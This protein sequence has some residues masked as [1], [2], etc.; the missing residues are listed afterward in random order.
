MAEAALGQPHLARQEVEAG[1]LQAAERLVVRRAGADVRGDV[2]DRRDHRRLVV[3]VGRRAHLLLVAAVGGVDGVVAR[4]AE[5]LGL[6]RQHRTRDQLGLRAVDDRQRAER[7]RRRL[8]EQPV[9]DAVARQQFEEHQ[10]AA[11]GRVLQL[12][13]ELLVVVHVDA[14][15]RH[16]LLVQI[17]P[18]DAHHG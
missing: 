11:L 7:L 5:V 9:R 17:A 4:G 15:A 12:G 2:V 18:V 16:R 14:V 8:A 6:D 13:V 3:R 10:L 1:D